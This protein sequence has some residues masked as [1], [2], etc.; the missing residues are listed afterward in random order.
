MAVI[1]LGPV[2]QLAAA[3]APADISEK[4]RLI[5]PNAPDMVLLVYDDA[6]TQQVSVVTSWCTHE[7]CHILTGGTWG[8]TDVPF[9]DAA[10]RV[11]TCPCHFSQFN[12]VDGAVVAEPADTPLTK[13]AAYLENGDLIVDYGGENA[14]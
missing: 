4:A 13:Y 3:D 8:S 11:I 2:S 14:T 5:D 12:L 7:G 10:S 1:N 9:Y 6:G